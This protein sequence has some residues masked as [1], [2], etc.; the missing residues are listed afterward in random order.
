MKRE[1]GFY[2]VV[3]QGNI[4]VARLINKSWTMCGNVNTYIDDDFDKIDY[5]NPITY[6]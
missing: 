1:N 3:F 4:T 5:S 2:F 6:L